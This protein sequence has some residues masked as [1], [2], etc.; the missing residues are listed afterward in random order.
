MLGVKAAL[1]KQNAGK[2]KPWRPYLQFELISYS[3]TG[4]VALQRPGHD[5]ALVLRG[6]ATQQIS[7]LTQSLRSCK[8]KQTPQ[9]GKPHRH[10]V[11]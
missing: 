3:Q 5:E 6:V 2:G 8:R 11:V 1:Q 10:E 4:M 9:K 7:Q